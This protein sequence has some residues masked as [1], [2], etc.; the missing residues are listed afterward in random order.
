MSAPPSDLQVLVLAP[1]GSDAALAVELLQ[2]HGLCAAN[3]AGISELCDALECGA[4]A[5]MITEEALVVED[6]TPLT[7]RLG[8][9]EPWSD[10]P[11]IVL[12]SAGEEGGWNET[13]AS[14]FAASGNLTLIERPCRAAT[15]VTA[16][17]V[18]LRAR[19]KQYEA[20]ELLYREQQA[21]LAAS[22]A[23]EQARQSQAAREA[24]LD[25]ERAARAEAEIANRLKDEFLATLSHELRTPLTVI[26]AWS[27]M[28]LKRFG[29]LDPQLTHGLSIVIENSMAQSKL[30][31]DLL[32]MSR[33]ISG[34]VS[35]E[36]R[37]VDL[38]GLIQ[39]AVASVRPAAE[40]K[41][42]RVVL[43]HS[44]G[45]MRVRGDA[46][47]L[48]QVF[49]NLLS[50]AIKFSTRGGE[51]WVSIE[52]RPEENQVISTIQD[53]GEGIAAEFLP[54]LFDRFR[55]ADGSMARRH[56][57]LG[58]GLAIV[59]QILEMHGGSIRAHSEGVGRGA[60]FSV[61]L[62]AFS[63]EG[64]EAELPAEDICAG[65]V[66]LDALRGVYALIVEDQPQ[67]LDILRRTLEEHG[68]EVVGL[69]SAAEALELLRCQSEREFNVLVSDIGMPRMDGY[70]LIHQVRDELAI[71]PERLPAVA[72]TAYA[73]PE[74]RARLLSCGFQDHLAKPYQVA[75]LV[76][77]V[78]RLARPDNGVRSRHP[79]S[80]SV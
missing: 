9:Q 30:I 55:Q 63:G 15:L 1:T 78:R 59:K 77:T 64:A 14:L 4:G 54:F 27:R 60:S 38:L 29:T 44:V 61:C 10:I 20:R 6:P 53:N 57:G 7:I 18:A 79:L 48:Q 32:D 49:W 70:G 43:E 28:L 36:A 50:N 67:M 21:R 33:I 22:H 75:Q 52:L 40:S 76:S 56:G 68:A 3:C 5:L 23:L 31:S 39:H 8:V 46:T 65:E 74:D 12:T 71:A 34:K 62:P 47:R 19:R 58:I 42:I 16:A 25:S 37:P 2:Q 13:L 41:Q 72:L 69:Q 66:S 26:V 80:T 24:L 45:P 73:R 17:Q 51:V 35:L 11:I